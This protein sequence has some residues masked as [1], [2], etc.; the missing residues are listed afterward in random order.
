[1]YLLQ[2]Q[3]WPDHENDVSRRQSQVLLTGYENGFFIINAIIH[4]FD[5]GRI[6]DQKPALGVSGVHGY[7]E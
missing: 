5:H 4:N 3:V 1:M 6:R 7:Q 2:N